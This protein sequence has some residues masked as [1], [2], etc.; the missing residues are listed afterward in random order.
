MN[1]GYLAGTTRSH[2]TSRLCAMMQHQHTKHDF[3]PAPQSQMYSHLFDVAS[4]I[5]SPYNL[6]AW[7]K[8]SFSSCF[9]LLRR[10]AMLRRIRSERGVWLGSSRSAAVAPPHAAPHKLHRRVAHA[11][12]CS[13]PLLRTKTVPWMVFITDEVILLLGKKIRQSAPQPRH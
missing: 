5:V 7:G 9:L 4:G 2:T 6:S 8:S 12:Q 3:I 13:A 10:H 1:G 11:Q